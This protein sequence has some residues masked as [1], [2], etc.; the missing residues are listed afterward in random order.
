MEFDI[1]VTADVH[2]DTTVAQEV[3]DRAVKFGAKTLLIAGDLCPRGPEMAFIL[4]DA[5]FNFVAV[6]G[7]CDSLWDFADAG[8]PNPSDTFRATLPDGRTVAMAHGH[9]FSDSESFPG[10][11]NPGD[12]LILGHTHVP[13]LVK[14][15]RGVI[16]LNPGSPTRPR[17]DYGSSYAFI[18]SK[19]IELRRFKKDKVISRLSF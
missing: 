10:G 6:R 11:L 16:I 17:G 2:S 9:Y 4:N 3:V 14:D 19:G 7:N 12:I 8:L 18:S 5:P 13:K 15:E 1:F